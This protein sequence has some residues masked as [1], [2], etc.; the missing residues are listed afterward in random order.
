MIIY[1]S[2]PFCH[3]PCYLQPFMKLVSDLIQFLITSLL[4][5]KSCVGVRNYSTGG[6]FRVSRR[7]SPGLLR[8]SFHQGERCWAFRNVL[9]IPRPRKQACRT[10]VGCQNDACT[11]TPITTLFS[12][13][14]HRAHY[15]VPIVCLQLSLYSKFNSSLHH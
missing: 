14:T 6:P 5:L 7:K 11:S 8:L 1:L 2:F 10:T 15:H 3:F 4:I 9:L 12:L 13:H